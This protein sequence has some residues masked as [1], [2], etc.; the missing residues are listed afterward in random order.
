MKI[1]IISDTHGDRERMERVLRIHPDADI[2]LHAGDSELASDALFPFIGVRGNCDWGSD[3]PEEITLPTPYGNLY[4][5][6][7]H[8]GVLRTRAELHR[9]NARIFVSGHTHVHGAILREDGFFF[10]PGSLAKPR[11]GENGTYLVLNV[12]EKTVTY[13]FYE[14]AF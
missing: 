9:L 12:T 14:M 6:H 7:G 8:H 4:I 11:D 5:T 13:R 10:N 3:L 2:Y 1:V